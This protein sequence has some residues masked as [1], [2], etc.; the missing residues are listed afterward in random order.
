MVS[1]DVDPKMMLLAGAV[2]ARRR[3]TARFE[4]FAKGMPREFRTSS[5][6]RL[7]EGHRR[8]GSREIKINRRY[9]RCRNSVRV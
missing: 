9:Q 4:V 7:S 2:L 6:L 5:Y 3:P 1:E 8:G